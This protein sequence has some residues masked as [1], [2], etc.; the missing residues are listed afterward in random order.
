MTDEQTTEAQTPPAEPVASPKKPRKP[1]APK[2]AAAPAPKK[3]KEP[4][5]TPPPKAPKKPKHYVEQTGKLITLSG[6][7]VKL[8]AMTPAQLKEHGIKQVQG[9][10]G[11]P[12][13]QPLV[14]TFKSPKAAEQ[15]FDLCLHA[16][17]ETDEHIECGGKT[18]WYA[19]NLM[20]GFV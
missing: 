9:E 12:C 19:D 14:L 17:E 13:A 15:F 16:E 5:P 8:R 20:G 18:E 3:A 11:K 6:T 1:R 2:A 4:A 10:I 7:D